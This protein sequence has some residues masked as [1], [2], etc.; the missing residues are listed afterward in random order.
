M[1]KEKP[2][3]ERLYREP[4]FYSL[5]RAVGYLG[6]TYRELTE[7]IDELAKTYD[8]R[9]LESASRYLLTFEGQMARDAKPLAHVSLR[10]DAKKVCWQLL[11]PP[12]EKWDEF[13]R[14]IRNPPPN[15]YG[16]APYGQTSSKKPRMAKAK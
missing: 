12:P 11:G 2:L 6:C 15:P 9:K 7:K 14:G 8:K 3:W 1:Y 13:Y 10:E 4:E 5:A 16:P